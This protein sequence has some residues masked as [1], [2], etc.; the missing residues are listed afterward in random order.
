MKILLRCIAL[1]TSGI[2]FWTSVTASPTSAAKKPFVFSIEMQLA[3]SESDG[4]YHVSAT[5]LSEADELD[6]TF[7]IPTSKLEHTK[8]GYE[9]PITLRSSENGQKNLDKQL[10]KVFGPNAS[11]FKRGYSATLFVSPKELFTKGGVI[12][13]SDSAVEGSH[14]WTI[15]MAIKPE[16][17]RLILTVQPLSY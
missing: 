14:F 5:G 16:S 3:A 17:K 12:S 8:F 11:L 13:V 2:L 6:L 4:I 15:T 10:S 9:L 7:E 1:I